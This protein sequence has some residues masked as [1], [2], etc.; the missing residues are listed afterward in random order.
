MTQNRGVNIASF[1]IVSAIGL[2]T[3]ET[4]L[5]LQQMKSGI[6]R[7][8]K[9]DDAQG[10]EDMPWQI[11]DVPVGRIDLSDNELRDLAE[12]RVGLKQRHQSRTTS[13]ALLAAHEAIKNSGLSEEWIYDAALI[14]ATTVGGMDV[15]PRFY[16]P[17][18][19]N[20]HGK[21]TDGRL[22]YV[23]EHPCASHTEVMRYVLNTG[24]RCHSTISTAC[25]SGANAIL[26][27]ARLISSGL[28]DVAIV[29]GVD[30]LCAFTMGGFNSL[31]ILSHDVCHP[32]S[33]DRS[34]LNL[35]EGAAYLVLT[36]DRVKAPSVGR[37]V[38]WANANDAHH[39]T[40][41][42]DRGN[43]AQLSMGQ[44]LAMSKRLSGYGL[45]EVSYI[46]LHG[47]ATPNNDASETAAIVDLWQGTTPPPFG[48]TK[49]LTG[50]TLAAAGAIEAAF[51]L[52]AIEQQ[53]LWANV[54]HS[55][56][57]GNGI[58][59]PILTNTTAKVDAV[60]SNSLGFGGN[61]T[62]LVFAKP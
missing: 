1:G 16:A 54:G 19:A 51:S 22:R 13:L 39:Q 30:P 57:M 44:A 49:G 5:S 28:I 8:P 43:G 60:L 46:N 4:L 37:L 42:S 35:G 6:R 61:C 36:S 21:G 9:S 15:T 7:Y 33:A 31:M 45:E 10:C 24:V 55:Q 32:L 3:E 48:S 29:G 26:F 53:T 25:S 40:A 38:G 47:T 11:L 14:S 50:H 12:R 41:L 23:A 27:G 20:E 56:P 34:G 58:P 17:Y 62:S 2:G 52:M 59:D 18:V